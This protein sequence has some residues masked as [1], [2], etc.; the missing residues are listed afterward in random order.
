M[1]RSFSSSVSQ[2]SKS[3]AK[4]LAKPPA[5]LPTRL[6]TRLPPGAISRRNRFL[7][8]L[9]PWKLVR[10]VDLPRTHRNAITVHMKGARVSD[11]I[12]RKALGKKIVGV[13]SIPM[14]LLIVQIMND[15]DRITDSWKSM[16]DYHRYFCRR[17]IEGRLVKDHKQ[18]WP[19][20]LSGRHRDRETIVDG[21]HRFHSYYRQGV[22][23]VP[24]IWYADE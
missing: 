24:A 7:V 23:F 1:A 20:V 6:I 3:P 14:N 4:P 8:S 19:I 11:K 5:K 15:R 18:R 9:L 13:V 17:D 2:H 21:W 12:L 16:D 22:K 10:L